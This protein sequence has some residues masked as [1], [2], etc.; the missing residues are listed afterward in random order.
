MTRLWRK[1]WGLGGIEMNCHEC[2][3]DHFDN[4]DETGL[5]RMCFDN[6]F[7]LAHIFCKKCIDM[8]KEKPYKYCVTKK[9]FYNEQ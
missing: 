2:K 5:K 8:A 3:R 7:F 6:Q 9:E 4:N 1:S